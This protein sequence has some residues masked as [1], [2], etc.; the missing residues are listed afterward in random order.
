M[1]E[2]P[3]GG[4][5]APERLPLR[6]PVGERKLGGVAIGLSYHLNINVALM[7]WFFIGI[8]LMMGLGVAV[9]IWLW[10]MI[11]AGDP[12]QVQREE[13]PTRDS[14][15]HS[16]LAPTWQQKVS[17]LPITDIAV[18]VVLLVVAGALVAM[19]A[20]IDIAN[21]LI[22]VLVLIAGAILGWSQL[23]AVQRA[24]WVGAPGGKTPISVVRIVGGVALAVVGTA[25]LTVGERGPG[26]LAGA[27]VPMLAVVIGAALVLAPWWLRL[28]R[29][30]GEERAARAREAERADIAAHLHDSVLQTL[31]LIRMKSADPDAVTTLA[32]AQERELRTWLYSDRSFEHSSL[33]EAVKQLGVEIEENSNVSIEIVVVGDVEFSDENA[34]ATQAILGALREAMVNATRHGEPPV[35]VFVDISATQVEAFVTDRGPG[36]MMDDVAP[37]RLGVRESIIGRLERRGGEVTIRPLPDPATGTEVRMVVPLVKE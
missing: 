4:P 15:L 26:E 23:D 22:P 32:R 33:S 18:G 16:G 17:K 20:G 35:T 29:E 34:S 25:L 8:S 14:A 30:L 2:T 6:R 19:R 37:D 21:T 27:I 5:D 11:P 28:V 3:Y 7:R 9:Y 1:R 10:V 31:A 12:R 24:R 36:F 13:K